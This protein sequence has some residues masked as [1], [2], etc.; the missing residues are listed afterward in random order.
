MLIPLIGFVEGD[1]IGTLVLAHHD[2]PLSDVADKM[3]EAASVR[4]DSDDS[5]WRLEAHDAVLDPDD[6]VVQ[7]GLSLLDRI[8]LRRGSSQ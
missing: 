8:D 6:T 7:A 1:T 3:R 4:V 5:S 2:M